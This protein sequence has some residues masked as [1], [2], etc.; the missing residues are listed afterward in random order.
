MSDMDDKRKSGFF[1]RL[2]NIIIIESLFVFAALALILF[3]PADSGP[4]ESKIN[5]IQERIISIRDYLVRFDKEE[6]RQSGSQELGKV[7]KE[8][9]SLQFLG[10]YD[11]DG[12]SQIENL[13]VYRKTEDD[14]HEHQLHREIQPILSPGFFQTV[15]NNPKERSLSSSV[16][17]D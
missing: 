6:L 13:Y 7:L 12:D 1:V 8:F 17:S 10:L 16:G 3:Y 4:V 5:E 14:L 2:S 9:P 15:A 11:F